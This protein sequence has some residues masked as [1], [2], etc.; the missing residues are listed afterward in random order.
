MD[1]V[2]N[3][4]NPAP[5]TAK[6]I[7]VSRDI[8]LSFG[9]LLAVSNFN[10]T[11]NP[12]ELVG[13]IGPNGAGKTTVFNI[14]TGVY[15]P[16]QGTLQFQEHLLNQLRPYKISQ[17]GMSRTFQNI[18]LFPNLSVLDNVLVACHQHT[19]HTLAD[20]IARSKRF[21][22]GEEVIRNKA[23]SL[24]GIFG[25]D[26]LLEAL[27]SELPY[28]QQRQLEIVRALATDPKLLLLDEPAAGMNPHETLRLMQLIRTILKQFS[29]TVVLIEHDMRV[30]MGICERILVLDHGVTIAE[31][32]PQAI[33]KNSK[34]I[35][36]YLGEEVH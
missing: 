27:A 10:L 29:L 11:V 18:R 30:V 17:L 7:L 15:Q 25:L 24:L 33:Q 6:P 36:A 26:G 8:S 4:P 2:G 22:W 19:D 35:E 3:E 9:G 20:S 13:L 14:M 21:Y 28:G 31:G 32:P 12:G 23:I 5:K 16:N 1:L 34:V